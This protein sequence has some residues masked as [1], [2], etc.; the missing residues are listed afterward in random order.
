[1]ALPGL[2]TVVRYHASTGI[3]VPGVVAATGDNWSTALSTYYGIA[4]PATPPSSGQAYVLAFESNGG[5]GAQ[6]QYYAA[7]E[8]TSVGQFSLLSMEAEDI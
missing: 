6:F 5:G 7:S 2:G 1:M 4:A 8:G 3:D